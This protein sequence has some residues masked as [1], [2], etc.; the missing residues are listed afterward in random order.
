[1]RRKTPYHRTAPGR[2]EGRASHG[3]TR[4]CAQAW[5]GL[6]KLK[7]KKNKKGGGL[8]TDC[9][10]VV[11]GNVGGKTKDLGGGEHAWLLELSA[12]GD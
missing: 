4:G 7:K 9:H 10:E 5:G 12:G 11:S 1:M 6:K 2:K 8:G 3:L